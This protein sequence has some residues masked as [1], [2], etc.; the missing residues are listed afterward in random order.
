MEIRAYVEKWASRDSRMIP[1]VLPEV[2]DLPELPLFVRQTLWV[3]MRDWE[4]EGSDSF[5]RFICGILARAPGDSPARKFGV[6]DV[7]EWQGMEL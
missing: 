5:Y 1:V 2:K 6:R 7:A 3:D 4:K